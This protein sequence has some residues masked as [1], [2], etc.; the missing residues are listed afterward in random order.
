AFQVKN[1]NQ[2]GR[3]NMLAAW[4]VD[5]GTFTQLGHSLTEQ[6]TL[7]KHSSAAYAADWKEFGLERSIGRPIADIYLV[8]T[9]SGQ[10]PQIKHRLTEDRYLQTSP[11]GRYLLYIENDQYWT[12]DTKTRASVNITKSIKTS[13][14]D[15]D[16]D[17]TVVQKPPFGVAGWT[18]NDAEVILYDK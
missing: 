9:N 10:R 5:A 3:R 4:H 18:K 6:V 14:I 8:D 11:G 2:D 17:N 1:A 13:F 15:Y 12:I 16:S 7:L